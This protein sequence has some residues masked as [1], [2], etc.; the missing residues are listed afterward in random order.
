[1]PVSDKPP[2]PHSQNEL[3]RLFPPFDGAVFFEDERM[4]DAG[5]TTGARP[6]AWRPPVNR[7]ADITPATAGLP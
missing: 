5:F 4:R 1:M 2:I 6:I 3:E 7:R